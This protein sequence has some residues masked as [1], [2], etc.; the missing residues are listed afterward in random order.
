MCIIDTQ[1]GIIKEHFESAAFLDITN[2]NFASLRSTNTNELPTTNFIQAS[3]IYTRFKSTEKC[4]C[5][6]GCNT[7]RSCKKSAVP[8]A[9]SIEN[10]NAK[11]VR[12][13]LCILS[14]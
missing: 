7:D 8:N 3:Q 1:N 9:T 13:L 12:L 5:S 10:Q 14:C 6:G 4:Q 2:E 11:I